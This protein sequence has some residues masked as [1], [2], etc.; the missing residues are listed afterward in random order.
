MV[1]DN[2]GGAIIATDN[3][4]NERTLLVTKLDSDGGFPWGEDGVSFYVDGYQANSLQL[5]S[6]SDGGAIIAWQE[7]AGIYSQKISSKGSQS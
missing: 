1:S 2:A 7:R 3:S 5:V 4:Y 6:D